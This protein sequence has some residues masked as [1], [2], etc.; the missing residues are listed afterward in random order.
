MSNPFIVAVPEVGLSRVASICIV[1]VFPAPFEPN[2]PKTSFSWM[3][4]FNLSTAVKLPYFLTRSRMTI[5]QTIE[6]C[7]GLLCLDVPAIEIRLSNRSD[8]HSRHLVTGR[9]EKKLY[10]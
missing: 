8:R 6:T 2:S 1:V 10:D 4:R 3:S 5:N 9:C 7:I